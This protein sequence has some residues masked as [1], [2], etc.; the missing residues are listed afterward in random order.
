M[1]KINLEVKKVMTYLIIEVEKTLK[2]KKWLAIR[3]YKLSIDYWMAGV[4]P[5]MFDRRS[6][7]SVLCQ[8][9]EN[10]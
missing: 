3:K 9:K 5:A 1:M 10:Q 8:M 4:F 7:D 2:P 6:Q